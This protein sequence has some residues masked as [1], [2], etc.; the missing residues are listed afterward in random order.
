M[1]KFRAP[2][3]LLLLLALVPAL[4]SLRAELPSDRQALIEEKYAGWSGV[5]RLWYFEGWPAGSGSASPW[6]SRCAAAFEKAHPG[7]YVQPESVDA[8]T[9]RGWSDGGMAP[10]DILLFPPGLLETPAG[11]LPLEGSAA[12]RDG[13]TRRGDWGGAV[14]A[15]PVAMGGY[16][17]VEASAADNSE[18]APEPEPFRRWD[19]ARAA[20][21]TRR[22]ADEGAPGEGAPVPQ[23]DL[24]LGLPASAP[25]PQSAWRRFANGEAGALLASQREIARLEALR[26]AGKGPEWSVD[27]VAPFTDQLLFAAV[28]CRADQGRQALAAE[29]A[30]SLLSEDG[31]G[32]LYRAGLFSVTSAPSGYGPS[33]A[34]GRMDALLRAASPAMPR[35]FGTGWVGAASALARDPAAGDD[36]MDLLRAALD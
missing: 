1:S 5:L 18:I 16:A 30:G 6:L 4:L 9:L 21:E 31:Q 15:L 26:E 7:V 22:D 35:A 29:F 32:Q 13:I 33:D 25:A 34:L 27:A 17:R 2:V 24:D 12:L 20:L 8:E 36:F 28:P 3:C 14:Y 23:P 11:L 19:V 10:P